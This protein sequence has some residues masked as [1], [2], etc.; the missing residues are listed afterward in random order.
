MKHP[1]L[2]ILLVLFLPATSKAYQSFSAPENTQDSATVIEKPSLT[3]WVRGLAYG[4]AE[5]CR[6]G[7]FFGETGLQIAWKHSHLMMG[8]DVR[9]R[10]GIFMDERKTVPDVHEAWAGYRSDFMDITLGNQIVTW[11]KTDGFNPTNHIT[12]TDYFLLTD[13]YTD[14][15]MSN[16]MLQA[17]FRPFRNTSLTLI[18]IPVFKPSVY[19]FDLFEMGEGTSFLPA[20][21][22]DYTIKNATYA[23]KLDLNLPGT[24]VSLSWTEGLSPEY[25]FG[26]DSI[27]LFPSTSI[28]Y[29]PDYYHRQVLGFDAAVPLGKVIFRAEAAWQFTDG[30]EEQM[31]IPHPGL[32]YVAGIEADILGVKTIAQYI[33][34]YTLDFTL[35]EEPVLLNPADPLAQMAY[36]RDMI[37]YE[38]DMFN[39]R[40]FYQQEVTNHAVS[41]TLLR[42]F[43]MDAFSAEATGYYNITSEERMARLSLAWYPSD[44]LRLTLGGQYFNGPEKTIFYHAGKVLSGAF[45]GAKVTF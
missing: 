38:S 36:A 35:P 22:P 11:G 6:V 41:L 39:R 34:G 28:L 16:F 2:F 8:T 15:M 7:A 4:G 29:K 10:D 44:G 27:A 14:Q 23:I 42:S 30:Y 21:S 24:D 33:G 45:L 12:P 43:A 17:T 37:L 1:L 19:R 3:G 13:D 32:N 25:G 18:G 40:I 31:Y 20:V 5:N 9:F 26:V